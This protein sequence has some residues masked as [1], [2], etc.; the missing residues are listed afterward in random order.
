MNRNGD[1]GIHVPDYVEETLGSA[2]ISFWGL[3]F[4]I[5]FAVLGYVNNMYEFSVRFGICNYSYIICVNKWSACKSWSYISMDSIR[6]ILEKV[7]SAVLDLIG[8][9]RN[10]YYW[11][12][13]LLHCSIVVH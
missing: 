1:Y 13:T 6:W 2:F 10:G 12:K 5:P 11:G 7:D 3:G 4:V 9:C 8:S